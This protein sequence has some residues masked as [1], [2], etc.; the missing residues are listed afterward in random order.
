MNFDSHALEQFISRVDRTLTH[1]QAQ[2]L[3]EGSPRYKAE[4]TRTGEQ[5]YDVP[6]LGVRLITKRWKGGALNGHEVCITVVKARPAPAWSDAELEL[7]EAA[8]NR[9][10]VE[11][12]STLSI[13]PAV[14][15]PAPI[16]GWVTFEVRVRCEVP[17]EM[18]GDRR[19]KV[20]RIL[21]TLVDPLKNRRLKGITIPEFSATIVDDELLPARADRTAGAP[22]R[23]STRPEP[24]R[25]EHDDRAA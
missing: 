15:V 21:A 2:A 19:A 25:R 7:L 3:L 1:E 4:R 6:E 12:L 10:A 9:A 18:A 13:V 23:P 5:Y 16:T 24:D 17:F 20:E 22:P 8:P 14:A 11:L